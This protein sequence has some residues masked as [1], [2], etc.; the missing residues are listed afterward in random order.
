MRRNRKYT[1][2][3]WICTVIFIGLCINLSVCKKNRF[4]KISNELFADMH[5]PFYSSVFQYDVPMFDEY[6][7]Y[8]LLEAEVQ[9]NG[10]KYLMIKVKDPDLAFYSED[11][12]IDVGVGDKA[13][14]SG[15]EPSDVVYIC[16]DGTMQ[17]CIPPRVS[18]DAVFSN[19]EESVEYLWKQYTECGFDFGLFTIR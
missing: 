17:E 2:F 4:S 5:N 15:I 18:A 9:E 19:K 7:S 13:D 11:W 14:I 8:R 3:L 1:V 16:Y 10:G 12:D 6:I